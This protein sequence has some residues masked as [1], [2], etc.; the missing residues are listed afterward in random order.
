MFSNIVIYYKLFIFS[1]YILNIKI[2]AVMCAFAPL[3]TSII[4]KQNNYS[5]K[6]DRKTHSVDS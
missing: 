5:A 2:N 4:S 1:K 6:I 3:K